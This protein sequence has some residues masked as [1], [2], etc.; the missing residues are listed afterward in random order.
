MTALETRQQPGETGTS[1]RCV[2]LF[3]KPATPGRVKT[4]LIGRLT[5]EQA[6]DLH[7]AFLSDLSR[8][9]IQGDFD[10]RIAWALDRGVEAPD[11][12]IESL[13]QRGDE[14]GD[15]LYRSL[16]DL[17]RDYPFVAAVGS[18]HP[19]LPLSRVHTAF[20]KLE[21]GADVVLGPAHDG[22]YYLIA[23]RGKV[24]NREL[25]SGIEWSGP[26]V[27]DTTLHRC[28]SLGLRTELLQAAFDVDTPADLDRLDSSLRRD[29]SIECPMTR[30]LLHRWRRDGDAE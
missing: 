16:F 27:F 8:R 22:G 28:R 26:S 10:L 30:K 11:F 13:V 24:L 12:G 20:D 23:L 3:T 17:S 4:R 1:L 29:P 18:D 6:A 19:D 2:A 15:R 25:F 7:R 14:L 5:A 9:L 21:A